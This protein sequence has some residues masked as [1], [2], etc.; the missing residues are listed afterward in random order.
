M[1]A[2]FFLS[3]APLWPRRKSQSLALGRHGSTSLPKQ[4]AS[5]LALLLLTQPKGI[6]GVGR[7]NAALH[8]ACCWS[9][10]LN[11]KRRRASNSFFFW[12]SVSVARAARA[13][14]GDSA[15]PVAG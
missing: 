3:S 8:R 12:A 10:L 7:L 1:G 5:A 11:S 9:K 14:I 2:A 13:F 6:N 4:F 15:H